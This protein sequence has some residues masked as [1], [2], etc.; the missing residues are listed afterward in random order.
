M[1]KDLTLDIHIFKHELHFFS[2][3]APKI[4]KKWDYLN[5]TW[6]LQPEVVLCL[7]LFFTCF[8]ENIICMHECMY[9]NLPLFH[10][11]VASMV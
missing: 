9:A 2:K 8:H 4:M 7:N 6:Q 5:P 3:I 1:I 11:L 10:Q